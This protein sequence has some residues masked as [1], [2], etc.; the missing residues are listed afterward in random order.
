MVTPTQNP[1]RGE[2]LLPL[3]PVDS[4][5][6]VTGSSGM[7]KHQPGIPLFFFF[8]SSLFK[9]SSLQTAACRW[10]WEKMV[11]S[12]AELGSNKLKVKVPLDI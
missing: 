5:T 8:L 1:V 12:K 7:W 10:E 3:I 6:M 2:S 11:P 4:V 9:I